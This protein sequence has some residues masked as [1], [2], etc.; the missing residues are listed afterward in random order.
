V[1]KIIT[2]KRVNGRSSRGRSSA[3]PPLA[4]RGRD[5]HDGDSDDDDGRRDVEAKASGD[6][7]RRP[8]PPSN[9]LFL[10]F[11]AS[12]TEG[13]APSD[14]APSSSSSSARATAAAAFG[15]YQHR[16]RTV[17][18]VER[19]DTVVQL[20]ASP[21]P[22]PASD[23]DGEAE[24]GERE[25]ER[26]REAA[27]PRRPKPALPGGTAAEVVDKVRVEGCEERVESC[28]SSDCLAW[29]GVV[30]V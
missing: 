17:E 19:D 11:D 3:G 27:S 10:D 12:V 9:D 28:A 2:R 29:C 6:A 8:Q 16:R 25:R 18:D 1:D 13:G 5:D 20:T 24:G 22:L 30:R 7:P 14:A 26:E 4:R 23:D 21:R 15:R